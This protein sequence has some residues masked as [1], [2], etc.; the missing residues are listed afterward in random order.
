MVYFVP[1]A[2]EAYARLGITGRAGYFASRAAPMGAVRR[3]WWSRPS[4]TSIPSWSAPPSRRRGSGDAG[5]SWSRRALT[6]WTLLSAAAGRRCGAFR[7]DG[8]GRA[9]GPAGGRGGGRHV[10]GRPLAAG[11]R[12][13]RGLRSHTLRLWHAQSILR[14]YRGDGHIALPGGARAL[15]LEAL[16]THAA[17][18]DVPAQLL[19]RP[20]PG[21]RRL[22]R[23]A[24]DTT[25][26]S[27]LA[28]SG[29]RRCASP[30]AG[31]A[32]RQAI[33]DGTDDLAAA[34]YAVLGEERCAE[35]RA[36]V[37]PWSRT[38]AEQ[39]R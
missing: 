16:V 11:T 18:G 7:R 8:S 27:G 13:C 23:V 15:G 20:G 29:R 37:R 14:E 32:Q 10:E 26:R 19:R 30:R 31:A 35:L 39:L 1:E 17:A 34:P 38:F 2:A 4:S 6:R 12:R 28:R 5:R 21:P 24:V 22:G 25:A 3:T 36:L 9:A 33:E